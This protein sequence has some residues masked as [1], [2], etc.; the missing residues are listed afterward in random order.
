MTNRFYVT[1]LV[2]VAGG[3]ATANAD[4]ISTLTYDDLAG[5]WNSGA[6]LFTAVAVDQGAAG[7]QSAGEASRLIAPENSASFDVGFTSRT[8]ASFTMSLTAT[9]TGDPAVKNG[10]G[11]FTAVDVNGDSITGS[12]DGQWLDLGNGFVAYNGTV[13]NA[14]FNN[15]SQDGKFDGEA[16]SF[17]NMLF[18]TGQGPYEGAAAALVLNAGSFFTQDFQNATTGSLIQI[19]PAP[20]SLALLGL[21]GLTA[22]R[23]RR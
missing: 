21:A 2:A 13:S 1:A 22:G 17:F 18:P 10:V 3:I 8:T 19:V 9:V 12:L 15:P 6:G 11:S 16:G 5:S 7:L 4:V 14:F 23:R 20:G